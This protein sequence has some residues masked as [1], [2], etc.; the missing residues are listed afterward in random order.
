MNWDDLRVLNA[1]ADSLS[2]SAAARHLGISQPKASRRLRALEE[3]LGARLFERLPSGLAPTLA[4]QQLIPLVAE[5]AKA[6]DAVARLR[7]ALPATASGTVR[8][9]AMETVSRY[10]SRRMDQLFAA[11]PG[12]EIEIL[13]A[14]ADVN[15]WRREADLQIRECL[16]EGA[17]LIVSRLGDIGYAVYGARDLVARQPAARSEARYADCDWIGFSEDRLFFPTQKKWLDSRLARPPR[18]RTTDMDVVLEALA[19]GVGLGVAPCCL[20]DDDPRL[21]RLTPPIEGLGRRQHLLSHRDMLREPVVRALA[22]ALKAL[23]AADRRWLS[24][25]GL[26]AA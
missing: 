10:L 2:L 23:F 11:A 25:E 22:D 14:H 21:E 8:I 6:A 20:A 13:P 3:M 15:L 26:S 7:P 5:M 1:A 9:S 12:V 17:S 4:G 19:E 24:G 16:P 18:L